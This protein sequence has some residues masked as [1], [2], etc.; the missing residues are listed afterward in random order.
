M[1]KISRFMMQGNL[2][3]IRVNGADYFVDF[4]L[5]KI[6][7]LFEKNGKNILLVAEHGNV[8]ALTA[9]KM[10]PMLK[11]SFKGSRQKYLEKHQPELFKIFSHG[12]ILKLLDDGNKLFSEKL[13]FERLN[14]RTYKGI[15]L[16]KRVS[17]ITC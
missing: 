11:S 1:N 4:E 2:Q 13:Q 8:F 9:D 14:V 16:S 17:A 6:A 12:T 15:L 3:M 5:G 10:I 7:R